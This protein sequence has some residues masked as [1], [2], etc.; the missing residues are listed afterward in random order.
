[1]K[2]F[3]LVS[4]IVVAV[5]LIGCTT[6]SHSQGPLFVPTSSPVT[7]GPGGGEVELAD[8]NRDG[9][10]DLVTK[11]LLEQRVAVQLG[12]GKGNFTPVTG[13][14]M[15][16]EYEPGAIALGDVNNDSIL[17]LGVANKDKDG[18]YV[19]VFI[20]DGRGNFGLVPG[21]PFRANPLI[22]G[23][24]PIIQIV[25][26]DEDGMK[27][28]VV[29]NGR[30]NTID[31][32]CGDGRGGLR[33]GPTTRLESGRDRFSFALGDV[34]QDGHLDLISVSMVAAGNHPSLLFVRRGDG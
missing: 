14:P 17:D 1:M 12:N 11:H 5:V 23:Y 21:S 16:F 33:R 3:V 30:R 27:D 7:V 10:L 22:R 15:K 31:I 2:R 28:V 25:D 29:A 34:D 24:K 18:E 13:G 20:G 4:F 32:L 6:Q 9:H 26:V 8:L 19:R